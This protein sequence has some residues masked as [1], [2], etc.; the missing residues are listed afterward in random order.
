MMKLFF[1]TDIYN[2]L[3]TS[4]SG[5]IRGSIDI[6]VVLPMSASWTPIMLPGNADLHRMH[7]GCVVPAD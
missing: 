5:V 4:E 1:V 6:V 3:V 2:R 7:L